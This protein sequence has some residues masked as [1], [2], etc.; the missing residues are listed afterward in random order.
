MVL[1]LSQDSKRVPLK[2]L[3]KNIFFSKKPKNIIFLESV[4]GE[5]RWEGCRAF[6]QSFI[7]SGRSII[8]VVLSGRPTTSFHLSPDP[9]QHNHHTKHTQPQPHETQSAN[10]HTKH[11]QPCETQPAHH[12][13]CVSN[14][15]EGNT[16]YHSPV[17]RDSIK[18]HFD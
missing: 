11:T 8:A 10:N 4:G 3:V 5:W 12:Q 13:F 14:D 18:S 17:Q 9:N 7:W 15:S 6:V 16:H 1:Q 2:L